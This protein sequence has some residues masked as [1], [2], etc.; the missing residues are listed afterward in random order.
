MTIP[1]LRHASFLLATLVAGV[2]PQGC[3]N[4]STE[5]PD[6]TA[7]DDS[8]TDDDGGGDDDDGDGGG[9][10]GGGNDGGGDDG[11]DGGRPTDLATAGVPSSG[12]HLPPPLHPCGNGVVDAGEACDDGLANGNDRE[13]TYTCTFNDCDLDA[14]GVC[15]DHGP[16]ADVDLYPCARGSEGWVGCAL[17]VAGT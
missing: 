2:A 4:E 13:C 9:N 17:G 8:G 11:G 3:D 1:K 7:A 5:P 16:A 10:D 14:H 6:A 12:P 15:I